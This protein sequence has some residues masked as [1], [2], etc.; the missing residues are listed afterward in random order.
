M[1]LGDR[2]VDV[3]R[4]RVRGRVGRLHLGWEFPSTAT[5]APSDGS[6]VLFAGF[7]GPSKGVDLLVDAWVQVGRQDDP[8]LV[9]AGDSHVPQWAEQVRRRGSSAAQPPRWLGALEEQPFAELFSTAALVVLPYRFSSA[10]SGILARALVAGRPVL[11]CRMPALAGLV[12]DGV[13]GRVIEPDDVTRLAA[14]LR[15]L[16]DDPGAR[17]RHGAA[18]AARARSALSWDRHLADL[19]DAYNLARRSADSYSWMKAR[20]VV[21]QL[22]S[23]STARRARARRPER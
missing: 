11:A 5:V 12:D 4:K 6:H 21:R 23:G 8:P 2:D 16:L 22:R 9:I 18:A 13:E 10:A 19:E 15:E 1:V 20:A 7:I 17:D 3:W 14:V